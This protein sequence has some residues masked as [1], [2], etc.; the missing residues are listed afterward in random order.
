MSYLQS[1]FG[2][3][4]RTA[5]IT[6]ASS[7][8]GL[9]MAGALGKAGASVIL[10]ARRGPPLQS[11]VDD[12]VAKG[13]SAT[14]LAMD[15]RD[16]DGIHAAV[17]THV[18]ILVNAAGVNPRPHMDDIDLA[19]WEDTLAVNLTAP[20]RLGQ[21]F[22]PAMARRGG[23]RIINVVSQQSFRAFGN[24]GAYGV[25]KAGLAALT[26]SQAEAWSKH[27]VLCNSI[28]P[29]LVDTP[30]TRGVMADE[31]KARKHAERTM[32][33]R[34]GRPED[35]E[36]VAVYLAGKASDGVTGQVLFVD[37]GYSAT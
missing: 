33:G 11:A 26:R 20:F 1:L 3:R 6:G 18:D 25:S 27:G 9:A 22:A 19:Q 14:A 37:G 13:I 5:L 7:G 36:G 12:L 23:G 4:G 17:A 29:G 35:F 32:V 8:I 24:S 16:A 15:V 2:L 28:A 10:V 31:E 30:M 21:L 34:N